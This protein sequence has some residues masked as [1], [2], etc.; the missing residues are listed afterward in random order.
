M[1]PARES[2]KNIPSKPRAAKPRK[3]PAGVE[4]AIRERAYQIWEEHGGPEGRDLEFWLQ[5]KKEIL[6]D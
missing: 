4:N 1:T 5:A 2:S 6:G 3:T